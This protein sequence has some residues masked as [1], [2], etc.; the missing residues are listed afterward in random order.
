[1]RTGTKWTI[2][3]AALLGVAAGHFLLTSG[4]SGKMEQSA[5]QP[6]QG[7]GPGA[8]ATP[9]EV[10]QVTVGRVTEK[11]TAV[12][13]LL[14]N[15]EV[16]IRPEIEGRITRVNFE[17]GQKVKEGRILVEI[18]SE[19]LEAQLAQVAA[20]LEIARLNHERMNRLIAN[21]NVSQ[22]ELDQ[23]ATALK[24]AEATHRLYTERLAETK[25]R[26]PFTGFLGTRRVSPGDY[27][28]PGRDIV[29]LEDIETLKI[30]FMVSEK[31]LS[32]LSVGQSVEVRVDAFPKLVFQGRVYFMDPRIDETSRAIRLRAR[33]PNP[34][35]KLRPGMFANAT[36]IVG[37]TD[38]ALLLP[39]EAVIPRRGKTYVFLV[40]E[41][42]AKW[43]EV[44]L[45]TREPGLVQVLGGLEAGDWVVRAGQQKIRDGA[46][47]QPIG[48]QESNSMNN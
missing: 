14:A 15:E 12:G 16:I 31:F 7:G 44:E 9:V 26:A 37:E 30:D 25:I 2:V 8:F 38:K 5:V 32:R 11:V 27:V 20:D 6:G 10:A 1:M 48:R 40:A 43:T 17:E 39:E 45:G 34:D 21:D 29:N 42:T 47:I 3:L 36:L 13:T 19:E 24:A 18:D 33:I 46:T 28:Q 41:N 4:R 23:A 22:Q 35:V